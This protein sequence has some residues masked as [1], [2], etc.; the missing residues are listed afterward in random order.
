MQ[1]EREQVKKKKKKK[2][3][4]EQV[5]HL[6]VAW[7][8]LFIYVIQKMT[9]FSIRD[10]ELLLFLIFNVYLVLRERKTQHE[11]GR[12][13]ERRRHRIWSRLQ[14]LSCQHRAPWGTWT[15]EPVRSWPEPKPRVRHLS[16]WATPGMG[17][18]YD[19]SSEDRNYSHAGRSSWSPQSSLASPRLEWPLE[20]RGH[21]E[22]TKALGTLSLSGWLTSALLYLMISIYA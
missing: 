10:G 18:Y 4:R 5:I 1:V 16:D 13:R 21:S 11:Q 6:A 9:Q 3:E 15:H 14:A 19:S 7:V 22:P 8:P 17:S 20:I 2:K 12:G